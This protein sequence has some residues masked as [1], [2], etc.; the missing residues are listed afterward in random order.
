MAEIENFAL[1]LTEI[2]SFT[3]LNKRLCLAVL[4]RIR[5]TWNKKQEPTFYLPPQIQASSKIDCE[6]ER[7]VKRERTTFWCI[8]M[9]FRFK[10][11]HLIPDCLSG[12]LP[13][14]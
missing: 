10:P 8:F 13:V 1:N 6:K 4:R 9:L 14:Q 5:K 12:N 7:I 2:R 3:E 11:Y